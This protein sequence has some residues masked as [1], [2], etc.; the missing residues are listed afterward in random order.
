VAPRRRGSDLPST[1]RWG[2]SL[3]GGHS[4]HQIPA[5]RC[6]VRQRPSLSISPPSIVPARA[7]D[8]S[9]L[10]ASEGG[11]NRGIDG[12]Q[13]LL[14]CRNAIIRTP[15]A[16]RGRVRYPG[17]TSLR[18]VLG[19][20]AVSRVESLSTLVGPLA[21]LGASGSGDQRHIAPSA[22]LP[23]GSVAWVGEA[24]R[25]FWHM[26]GRGRVSLIIACLILDRIV[27]RLAPQIVPC[28]PSDYAAA[29]W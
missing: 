27:Q 17:H 20:G 9:L 25:V 18:V 2:L 1:G 10:R 8:R 22:P 23:F 16:R 24:F 11:T 6:H 13:C 26:G 14:V 7:Q 4:Q 15:H 5:R 12:R 19:N 3:D 29:R 21:I 28:W